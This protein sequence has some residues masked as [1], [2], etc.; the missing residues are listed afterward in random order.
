M[1]PSADSFLSLCLLSPLRSDPQKTTREHGN[2][3]KQH[4]GGQEESDGGVHRGRTAERRGSGQAGVCGACSFVALV[5]R[6]RTVVASLPCTGSASRRYSSPIEERKTT[7]RKCRELENGKIY[8]PC[9]AFAGACPCLTNFFRATSI[10]RLECVPATRTNSSPGG[11]RS[12]PFFR[13]SADPC[14]RPK[15]LSPSS[16]GTGAG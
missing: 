10:L 12:W 1:T 8:M 11:A 7:T 2:T 5:W 16:V 15:K 13:A 3:L 4:P 6:N 14:T 9:S